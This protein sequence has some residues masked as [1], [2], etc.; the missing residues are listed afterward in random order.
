VVDSESALKTKEVQVK[1]IFALLVLSMAFIVPDASAQVPLKKCGPLASGSYLLTGNI[2][3]IGDCFILAADDITLDLGGFAITGNGTGSAVRT[4]GSSRFTV[5]NGAIRNFTSGID[6]ASTVPFVTV[7]RLFVIGTGADGGV[8]IGANDSSIVR[9]SVVSNNGVGIFVGSRS[10]ITNNTATFNG[11]GYNVGLGSTVIG[12]TAGSNN[13]DGFQTQNGVTVANN[14]A[15]ANGR[16][17]FLRNGG[18]FVG[19]T[20]MLS[21]VADVFGGATNEVNNVPAP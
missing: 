6:L 17:G 16:W 11:D 5:R 2:A 13:R 19:N 4:N 1:N 7:D 15:F 21:G 14:T 18:N 10:V 20:A 9:D 12:N 8:G 3:A